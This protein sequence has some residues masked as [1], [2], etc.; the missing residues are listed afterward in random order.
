MAIVAKNC[1]AVKHQDTQAFSSPSTM[2][3]GLTIVSFYIIVIRFIVVA[4]KLGLKWLGKFESKNFSSN[5]T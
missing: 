4:G 1:I 2:S 5:G 3:I